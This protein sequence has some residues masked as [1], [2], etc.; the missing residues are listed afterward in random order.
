[1]IGAVPA[2]GLQD[3]FQESWQQERRKHV[4]VC[5]NRHAGTVHRCPQLRD[6]V[7]TVMLERAIV[8]REE[9]LERRHRHEDGTAGLQVAARDAAQQRPVVGDVFDDIEREH[10][11]E[12]TIA[13][14]L[15]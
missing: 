13:H 12:S 10:Q 6:T 3:F 15:D 4:T 9:R 14:R 7:A 2:C 8:I 11:I 5:R 1:M